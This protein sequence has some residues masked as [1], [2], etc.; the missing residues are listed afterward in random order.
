MRIQSYS[1]IQAHIKG[2]EKFLADLK[3]LEKR[4]PTAALSKHSVEFLH[5]WLEEHILS[6][7]KHYASSLSKWDKKQV[8]EYYP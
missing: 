8:R 2:H 4:A 7:D 1:D 5:S 3:E 6:D